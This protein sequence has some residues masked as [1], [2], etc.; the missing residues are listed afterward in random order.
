MGNRVYI[1]S[2]A[3][4]DKDGIHVYSFDENT[5]RL[6]AIGSASGVQNPSFLAVHPNR[7]RLYSVSEVR[8]VDGEP[9]GRVVAW[10]IGDD[11]ELTQLNEQL[12][13]G[14]L[15]CHL[16]VD[17]QGRYVFAVN[18]RG[19]N[20]VMYP[21]DSRGELEPMCDQA[22]HV[23]SSVNTARQD[24][25]HPHSVHIDPSG[26][27]A[28]VQDLGTDRIGIYIIDRSHHRL[29]PLVQAVAE[30]GAGPRQCC[31]HPDGK[32]FYVVNEL[33][34]TVA[35]YESRNPADGMAPIQTLS[36]LPEGYTGPNTGADIHLTPQGDFLY[37]SNR[38]HD[39]LALFEVNSA[40]G[41]LRSVG[42]YPSKGELPHAFAIS[43]SGKYLLAANLNAN[44]VVVFEVDRASGALSGPV[45]TVQVSKPSCIQLI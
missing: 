26:T 16:T 18:Y 27:Y 38:G 44:A 33:N 41:M 17:P 4:Q 45:Q 1:G 22:Q 19:G 39:S 8:V 30:A 9:G 43:P 5:G 37:A 15:P 20:V 23:G 14:G 3:D 32:W 6:E 35:V 36:T 29:L 7:K 2:Y 31:L 40:T 24:S 13:G 34:S 11:G 12:S 10:Q 25:P 28:Y 21:L 42:H